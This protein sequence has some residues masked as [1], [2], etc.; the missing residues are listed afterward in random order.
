[1]LETK[2]RHFCSYISFNLSLVE[3]LTFEAPSSFK[4]VLCNLVVMVLN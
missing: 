4:L 3:I 2:M 1:M